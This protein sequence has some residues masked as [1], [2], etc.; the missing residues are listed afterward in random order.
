MA[1]GGMVAAGSVASARRVAEQHA[2][3]S[4]WVAFV[5][6]AFLALGHAGLVAGLALWAVHLHWRPPPEVVAV[7]AG[8]V[9][10][11]AGL[12][13]LVAGVPGPADVYAVTRRDVPSL[14]AVIG[15]VAL[16]VA[17]WRSVTGGRVDHDLDR[18]VTRAGE[19]PRSLTAPVHRDRPVAPTL[20][21][22]VA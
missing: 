12:T 21:E 15:S 13:W 7:W 8:L 1:R 22:A 10:A 18:S 17:A 3:T 9:L 16:V 5:A 19:L 20:L 11:L 2:T 4:G 6:A 14:L